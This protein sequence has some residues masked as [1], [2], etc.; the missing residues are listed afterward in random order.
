MSYK[1][2]F[3][4][5]ET[6]GAEDINNITKRLVSSGVSDVF[7]NGTPYNLLALNDIN[8]M[9]YTK[10]AVP[11]TINSL[12]VTSGG[13][14]KILINP[15]V[16]FFSDGAVMEIEAGGE[17]LSY[18]AGVKNYV[19]LKNDLDENNICYPVCSTIAPEGDFVLLAEITEKGV[20]TDKRTYAKGKLPSYS[21]NAF[22][23]TKIADRVYVKDKEAESKSYNIGG[24]TYKYLL[25]VQDGK[26]QSNPCISIYDFENGTYM[27]YYN[28][29]G[30]KKYREDG[31]MLYADRDRR[32]LASVSFSDGVLSLD[33]DF[34]VL[35]PAESIDKFDITLYLF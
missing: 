19:Y 32:S 7:E 14:G 16:C 13:D 6:Y 34:T 26:G 9:L 33:I 2:S 12:K 17:E 35:F 15:G 21:S 10:G 30:D 5:N 4:D 29:S 20:I 3:C 1:Y 25:S 28:H 11:E 24:N 27:S 8:A 22:Y 23:N 18:E 31:L